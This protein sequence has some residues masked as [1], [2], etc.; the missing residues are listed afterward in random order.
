MLTYDFC[1]LSGEQNKLSR[2]PNFP[3]FWID[4]LKWDIREGLGM[5]SDVK[6]ARNLTPSIVTMETRG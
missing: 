4:L 5:G 6:S 3:P 1:S 2:T